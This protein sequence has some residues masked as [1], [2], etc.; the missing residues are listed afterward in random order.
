MHIAKKLG[1]A[2]ERHAWSKTV[3]SELI[4]LEQ[5]TFLADHPKAFVL[6]MDS[7][8]LCGECK[9]LREECAHPMMARPA[10]ESMAVDVFATV[11][12]AGFPIKVL[13][14]KAAAMN[15]YAFLLVE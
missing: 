13:T 9:V 15:R 10:P 14:D 1:K 5:Q 2:E 4:K 3:N 8:H 7:C 6:F 12:K 11:R